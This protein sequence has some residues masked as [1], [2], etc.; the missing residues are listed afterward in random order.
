MTARQI[1]KLGAQLQIG[2][3]ATGYH[4]LLTAGLLEGPLALDHQ[5]LHHRLF[6]GA[7]DIGAGLVI[8]AIGGNAVGGG[9]FEA[10][11]AEI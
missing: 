1:L 6:K 7:G 3:N 9:G 11:E 10:A 8:T 4:Q 5:R 2:A